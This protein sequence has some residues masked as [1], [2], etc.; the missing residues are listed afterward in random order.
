MSR[1]MADAAHRLPDRTE[2]GSVAIGAVLAVARYTRDH[3]TRVHRMQHI[4]P[5]AQFL[6]LPRPEVLHQ[7]IGARSQAQ[8]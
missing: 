8:C 3:Q 5:E 7:H 1:Q 4:W 2:G 6:K